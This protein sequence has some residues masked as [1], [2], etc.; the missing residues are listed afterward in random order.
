MLVAVT[1]VTLANIRE[2]CL[3]GE[4]VIVRTLGIENTPTV[5]FLF[6]PNLDSIPEF[7]GAGEYCIEGRACDTHSQK[8]FYTKLTISVLTEHYSES[9]S[10]RF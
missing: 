3:R 9:S 7:E 5:D 4:G 1:S 6:C 10:L 2:A 8:P